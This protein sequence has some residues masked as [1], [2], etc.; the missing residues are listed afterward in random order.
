M[1]GA[2]TKVNVPTESPVPPIV[3]TLTV[4]APAPAA[5]TAVICVAEL[6]V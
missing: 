4:T 3:V 2:G 1:V 5:V 6:T